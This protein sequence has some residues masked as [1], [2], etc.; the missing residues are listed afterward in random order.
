MKRLSAFKAVTDK[1]GDTAAGIAVTN[2][3]AIVIEVHMDSVALIYAPPQTLAVVVGVV[4]NSSVFDTVDS[5]AVIGHI[6]IPH[7][8]VASRVILN[9]SAGIVPSAAVAG[10]ASGFGNLCITGRRAAESPSGGS[11]ISQRHAAED[12]SPH[13]KNRVDQEQYEHN[14]QPF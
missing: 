12:D 11:A 9:I 8:S 5:I 7:R 2:L 13:T 3:P 1:V 14:A 10:C 4:G 6:S